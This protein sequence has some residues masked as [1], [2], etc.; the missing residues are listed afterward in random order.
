M[1]QKQECPICGPKG[2]AGFGVSNGLN[3]V[4]CQG[5]SLLY[6]AEHEAEEDTRDF[7]RLEHISR[8]EETQQH[9]VDWRKNSLEREAALIRSLCPD[10][11]RLCDVGTAS[12]FFL[13]QFAEDAQWQVE[14]VEPSR[15][16][17]RYA[18]EHFGLKVHEG[19]LE[20]AGYDDGTFDVVTSLDSFG[21]HRRPREDMAEFL[22]IL[23]P[24]GV[25][26]VEIGGLNFR[27]MKGS[28][29]AALLF[30][31]G[32]L[33]LNAGVN[34]FFYDRRTLTLL[35]ESVGFEAESCHPESMPQTGGRMTRALKSAYDSCS[36][37]LYRLTNGRINVA[38]KEFLVFRKPS[39][40]SM[41]PPTRT[42]TPVQERK[43][44]A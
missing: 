5:C 2:A 39:V 44:A 27:L 42:T 10:G 13:H 29:P 12:G 14:G 40:L 15:V 18:R 36:G 43:H 37:A 25:L 9:Y 34:S 19:F 38:P 21:C 8:T 32:G 23:K 4:R 31:G 33:H 26:A 24:G 28:G 17:A 20:E 3:I 30:Y 41:S 22:R 7:F 16:S 1:S 11:G 6:V 35:A